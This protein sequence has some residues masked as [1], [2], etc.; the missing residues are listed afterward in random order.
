MFNLPEDT[1]PCSPQAPLPVP[2][3]ISSIGGMT[4]LVKKGLV[5]WLLSIGKSVKTR[6]KQIR[7]T[8]SLQLFL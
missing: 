3:A 8:M 6:G 7:L 1:L 4:D 5:S 2:T